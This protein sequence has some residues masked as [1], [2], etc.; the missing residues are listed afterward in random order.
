MAQSSVF[1]QADTVIYTLTIWPFL[2]YFSILWRK[3]ELPA[4][5]WAFNTRILSLAQS[6]P[7]SLSDF[8]LTQNLLW[9]RLP[10]VHRRAPHISWLIS[11]VEDSVSC[12]SNPEKIPQLLSVW[13][14][15]EGFASVSVVCVSATFFTANVDLIVRAWWWAV[16][17]KWE[18]GCR[19]EWEEA[20][21][22][23]G[24]FLIHLPH[25]HNLA[26]TQMKLCSSLPPSSLT[27]SNSS[28]AIGYL[29]V[30][31]G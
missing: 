25:H 22:V 15:G 1:L 11:S 9:C 23:S 14:H 28:V 13:H 29:P 19:K 21:A 27:V 4:A 3:Y 20:A 17:N 12:V 6:S 18:G 26:N 24:G 5:V 7:N 16:A 2:L 10:V 8:N 30:P 31:V